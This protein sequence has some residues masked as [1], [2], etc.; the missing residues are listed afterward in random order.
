MVKS[1]RKR[2]TLSIQVRKVRIPLL[3]QAF[4]KDTCKGVLF[5]YASAIKLA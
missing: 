2:L 3:P 5:Y 4:R 1:Q